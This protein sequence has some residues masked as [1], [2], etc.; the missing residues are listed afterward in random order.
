[1]RVDLK[2]LNLQLFICRASAPW[3]SWRY[4]CML[5]RA[6]K[7]LSIQSASRCNE[8]SQTKTHHM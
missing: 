8:N 4:H 2:Q 1:M 5:L 3:Y 7:T 6:R